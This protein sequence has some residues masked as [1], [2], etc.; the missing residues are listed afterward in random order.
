MVSQSDPECPR[1]GLLSQISDKN[2]SILA[3]EYDSETKINLNS[4]IILFSKFKDG[5]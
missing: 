2:L 3:F 1:E 5:V 4:T